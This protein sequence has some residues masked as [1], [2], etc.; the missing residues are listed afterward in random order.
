MRGS[1]Y[2]LAASA[3]TLT[4]GLARTYLM[5]L[6]LL[7]EEI[8]RAALGLLYVELALQ[9]G[10]MGLNSA[11]VHHRSDEESLRRTFH[12]L[13]LL[14]GAGSLAA[15]AALAPLIARLHPDFGA[16]APLLLAFALASLL[17]VFNQSQNA[18]LE[19]ALDFKRLA[20]LDAA[21]AAA[22]LI[23]GPGMAYLGF[24]AWAVLGEYT[25]ARLARFLLLH[26]A[27]RPW[28][29]RLGW[30]GAH[31][32]WFWQFGRSVWLESNLTWLLDHFDDYWTGAALGRNPLGWYSKAW[33]FSGYPRRVVANPI[34]AVFFP[35]FASLQHDRLKLSRAFFRAASLM[36]RG[37]AL[38]ALLLAAAAP[39][40]FRLL[41]PAAWQPMRFTFQL[42][43][44]YALLDPLHIAAH[45]LLLAAGH[46]RRIVRARWLQL[47]VFIPAVILGAGGLG[48]AGV[49]LAADLM[50]LAGIIALFRQVSAVVD[51]SPRKLW[52]NPLLAMTL[53]GGL[54]LGLLSWGGALPD[55]WSLALKLILLP[56]CY[57][58][59]L[60]LTERAELQEGWRMIHSLLKPP[61]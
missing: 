8:G 57:A 4:L 40:A 28:R 47:A 22:S 46:P 58:A 37:G 52:L 49:A 2:S 18:M 24:G 5:L 26:A 56:L 35:A 13:N 61:P 53:S 44:V 38:L 42:M 20:V 32:R 50:M 10:G 51:Y 27:Y 33:E 45:R 59:V 23:A 30:D 31:A 60:W 9:F 6:W 55:A 43:L 36:L 25:A 15:V 48:I 1:A 16:L 29:P 41:L 12:S 34:I 14:V 7:P 3:V 21:S 39:E 54:T 17:R 11:F 19:K